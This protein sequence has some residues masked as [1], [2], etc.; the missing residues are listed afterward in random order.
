LEPR[1]ARTNVVVGGQF[2]RPESS[3]FDDATDN[4]R[5]VETRKGA[6]HSPVTGRSCGFCTQWWQ[7]AAAV[8]C[9]AKTAGTTVRSKPWWLVTSWVV[10]LIL[11][12]RTTAR[13]QVCHPGRVCEQVSWQTDNRNVNRCWAP[14]NTLLGTTKTPSQ[15]ASPHVAHGPL[16][17]RA[18]VDK[19]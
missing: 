9:E 17:S 15:L 10:Q 1:R 16:F 13:L 7:C 3:L 6:R 5:L 4:A 19:F 18:P 8:L 11:A 2:A 12:T 14:P